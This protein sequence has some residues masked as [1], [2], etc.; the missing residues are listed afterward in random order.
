MKGKGKKSD[1]CDNMPHRG[2]SSG[3]NGAHMPGHSMSDMKRGFKKEGS[4]E[5]EATESP[6]FEKTEDAG[7]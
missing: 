6:S 5:E 1:N 4:M 3:L 2:I 7:K